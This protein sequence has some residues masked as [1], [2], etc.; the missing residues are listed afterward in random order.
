MSAFKELTDYRLL[1]QT[2]HSLPQSAAPYVTRSKLPQDNPKSKSP[3]TTLSA[4]F[5][6]E[7]ISW[8]Y[9]L[10]P[11]SQITRESPSPSFPLKP[12]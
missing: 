3:I 6:D 12:T 9:D 8:A 4:K 10:Q 2:V 11:K 7:K 1:Y 5:I